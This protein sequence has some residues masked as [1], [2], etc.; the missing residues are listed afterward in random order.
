MSDQTDYF[1]NGLRDPIGLCAD[2]RYARVV[3]SSRNSTFYLC[4]RS[5]VDPRYARYPRLPVLRCTGYEPAEA[6]GAES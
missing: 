6:T 5:E 2:C 4:R 1:S 3:Q